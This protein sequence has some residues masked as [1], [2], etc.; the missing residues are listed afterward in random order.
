MRLI[1]SFQTI[2]IHGTSGSTT[3]STMGSS[4]TVGAELIR[5]TLSRLR[6]EAEQ[7]TEPS[8]VDRPA[9][10]EHRRHEQ[11][12]VV[13]VPP[14]RLRPIERRHPEVVGDQ[15]ADPALPCALLGRPPELLDDRRDGDGQRGELHDA[16][17]TVHAPILSRTTAYRLGPLLRRNRTERR[18]PT[19]RPRPP[20]SRGRS[21]S[22]AAGR[23][24]RGPSDTAVAS[25]SG[26]PVAR[27]PI[28]ARSIRARCLRA[29]PSRSRRRPAPASA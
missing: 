13:G 19:T 11:P 17:H 22:V 29:P 9:H 1:G 20:P 7:P 23:R 2:T 18:R 27:P 8:G 26:T 14:A 12:V 25:R 6:H 21:S 28:A 16:P 4:T 5:P 10:P 24:P 3:S 15:T